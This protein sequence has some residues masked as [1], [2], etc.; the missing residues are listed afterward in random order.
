[1]LVSLKRKNSIFLTPLNCDL[2]ALIFALKDSANAF[3]FCCQNSLRLIFI[4]L[5]SIL[6][7]LKP[8]SSTFLYQ[9]ASFVM[10]IWLSLDEVFFVFYHVLNSSG[11]T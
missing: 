11:V 10:A 3:Y 6:K 8:D 2:K 5:S 7:F 4:V 9:Y 1:M